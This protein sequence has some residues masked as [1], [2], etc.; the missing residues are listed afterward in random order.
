MPNLK[1]QDI[2]AIKFKKLIF[3]N[4]DKQNMKAKTFENLIRKVVREEIDYALRREIKTLKEIEVVLNKKEGLNEIIYDE[5][6]VLT[7][8]SLFI[9]NT[10]D[11]LNILQSLLVDKTKN[12]D[13]H[14]SDNQL[15]KYYYYPCV[16][17]QAR[18]ISDIDKKYNKSD[19]LTIN[20]GL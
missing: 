7:T 15:I 19:I 8:H 1:W 10:E 16:F 20:Y 4:K 6:K 18:S 3:I 14:Y 2:D 5:F 11:S 9:K 17:N 12:I 13:I